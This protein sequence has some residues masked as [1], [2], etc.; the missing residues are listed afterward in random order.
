MNAVRQIQKGQPLD[1]NVVEE[2]RVKVL[3]KIDLSEDMSDEELFTII[4]KM[5]VEVSRYCYI[6]LGDRKA[7]RKRLFDSLR[8]MDVLQELLEDDEITEIMVNGPDH[9]FYERE[10]ILYPWEKRISSLKKLEDIVQQTVSRVNRTVNRSSPI[11][12]ARLNDGSRIH[13]VLPPI[14]LDGPILTIRKFYNKPL[15]IDMLVEKGTLTD[16]AAGFLKTMVINKYNIF[17]SGGT[18]SG[19]TTFLNALSQFIPQNERIVT[20]EDSAELKI[21]KIP[22]LVRLE[23]RNAGTS[24][25]GEVSIRQLIR[26]SLRM[27]PSR[28]IVGEVRDEAALDMLQAMNTGHEGSLSSGHSNSPRDM[29][30]RLETMVMMGSA[31]P[32]PAIRDQIGS[33]LDILIHLERFNDGRRQ[34]VSIMEVTG[35]DKK[36]DTIG[37]EPLFLIEKEQSKE[38]ME[39]NPSAKRTKARLKKVGQGTNKKLAY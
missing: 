27:R 28:I 8:R 7:Y 16:E 36:T 34:V 25:D 30:S 37:L 24:G 31:L 38:T 10:G 13:V 14:S 11:V 2:L 1:D 35:Y 39:D 33:A 29:L 4:D 6:L 12:D 23:A 26:A 17:I 3:S 15:T 21:T 19:K 18:G 32:L 20:I 22:N 5:I 9:I